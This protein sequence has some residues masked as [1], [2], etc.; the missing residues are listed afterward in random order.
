[1]CSSDLIKKERAALEDLRTQLRQSQVEIKQ[2]VDHASSLRGELDQVR[3]TAGQLAQDYNKLRDISKVAR[4]DSLSATEAVKEVEKK[5][6]P[7]MQLQELSKTTDEKLTSLNALA[8]HVNQKT[9]ALESQRHTLDRAAVEANRLNEM[10][11]NM[12]VQIGKLNEA[13]K[14]AAKTEET[15]E[16]GRAHV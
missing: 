5:L 15:V 16:I 7:L 9:K 14:Q 13:M 2:S 10:V 11:W 8:E 4:E 3:S 1:M 6:G 12:D